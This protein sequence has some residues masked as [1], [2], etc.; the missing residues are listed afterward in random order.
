MSKLAKNS[1]QLCRVVCSKVRQEYL[2][3]SRCVPFN[4]SHK[5]V[6]LIAGPP[7]TKWRAKTSNDAHFVLSLPSLAQKQHDREGQWT[8]LGPPQPKH[9]RANHT[10]LT[11]LIRS[12]LIRVK[13][14]NWIPWRPHMKYRVP[15]FKPLC[16]TQLL[17]AQHR[18]SI[19]SRQARFGSTWAHH[20]FSI[21]QKHQNERVHLAPCAGCPMNACFVISE[22]TRKGSASPVWTQ[23]NLLKLKHLIDGCVCR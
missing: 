12:P 6:H 21:H 19:G 1:T 22:W 5:N 3:E 9:A 20:V 17:N 15:H 2:Q 10:C 16:P 18:H 23:I 14:P 11:Q 4:L 13:K 8:A 7:T